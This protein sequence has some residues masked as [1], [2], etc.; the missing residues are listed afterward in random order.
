VGLLGASLSRTWQ[1]GRTVGLDL[2]CVRWSTRGTPHDH[3]ITHAAAGPPMQ[4]KKQ[5]GRSARSPDCRRQYD[6]PT[7]LPA[8]PAAVYSAGPWRPWP[9]RRCASLRHAPAGWHSQGGPWPTA[10][11]S[12]R[13]QRDVASCRR[14]SLPSSPWT[15]NGPCWPA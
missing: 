8:H 13:W 10:A 14:N 12:K 5:A 7:T 3:T 1:P 4:I 15:I 11:R 2:V 9:V 6:P